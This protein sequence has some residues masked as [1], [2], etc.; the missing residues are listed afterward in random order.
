MSALQD[1]IKDFY[2][3]IYISEWNEFILQVKEEFSEI[4]ITIDEK[5]PYWIDF[6]W[7]GDNKDN[8]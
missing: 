7:S 1:N 5:L 2:Q 8:E 6:D 3:K 4:K